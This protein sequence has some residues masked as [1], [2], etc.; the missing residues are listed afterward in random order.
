MQKNT[1]KIIL[2]PRITEKGAYMSVLG[3]YVFNVGVDANKFEIASA[4][5]EL[6]KVTPRM[7]RVVTIPRKEV[8]T[9]GTNRKGQTRRGKKAYVYLKKGQTIDIV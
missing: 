1:K 7:I 5:K 9:R 2:S 4:M 6:F 8:A 3:A